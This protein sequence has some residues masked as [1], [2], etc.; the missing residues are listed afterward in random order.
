[1]FVRQH[2]LYIQ[3]DQVKLEESLDQIQD[4]PV[5]SP[6]LL[7]ALSENL[8]SMCILRYLEFYLV[9]ISTVNSV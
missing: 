1:M 3:T 2:R 4:Y 8:N 6:G 9:D 7:L 5:V